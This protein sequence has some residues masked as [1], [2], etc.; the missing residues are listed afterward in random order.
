MKKNIRTYDEQLEMQINNTLKMLLDKDYLYLYNPLRK[1][2]IDNNTIRLSWNNHQSGGFNL[3]DSFL[4]ISQYKEIL[5]NGSY[6]CILFDGSLIRVSYTIKN[7]IL[8]SHNLLWWPA[9]YKYKNVTL[10]DVSPFQII[11]DFLEDNEWYK[12]IEMRSPIRFDYDPREITVKDD[13]PPVHMHIEHKDCRIFVEKPL[14]F[15]SFISYI[16]KNFYPQCHIYIN[17]DDYIDFKVTNNYKPLPHL[18]K[19]IC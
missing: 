17:N 13:H 8:I 5:K 9:P 12:N 3:G 19:I 6:L 14:C 2:K 16:F 4:Y 7:N 11:D 15:N 10:K 18:T 1:E